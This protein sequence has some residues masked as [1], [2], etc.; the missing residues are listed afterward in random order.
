MNISAKHRIIET[1]RDIQDKII[2]TVLLSSESIDMSKSGSTKLLYIT[3]I[4]NNYNKKHICNIY[5][6]YTI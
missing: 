4:E 1:A 2:A 6:D 5:V 3:L